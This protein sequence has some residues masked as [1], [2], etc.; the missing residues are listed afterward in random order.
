MAC[1]A[2]NAVAGAVADSGRTAVA[3]ALTVELS[4]AD[5]LDRGSQDRVP[6]LTDGKADGWELADSIGADRQRV[7]GGGESG[8]RRRRAGKTTTAKCL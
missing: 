7:D 1:Q 4:S 8:D 5:L 2:A 3:A 6:P